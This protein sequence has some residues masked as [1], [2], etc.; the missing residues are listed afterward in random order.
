MILNLLDILAGFSLITRI[1]FLLY[2]LGVLQI[3]KGAWTVYTSFKA[4]FFLEILGM[5]DMLGGGAM[6]LAHYNFS[7]AYFLILGVLMIVKGAF[8]MMIR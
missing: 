8:L 1:N 7:S 4:G 3:L 5:I 2:P 6:L